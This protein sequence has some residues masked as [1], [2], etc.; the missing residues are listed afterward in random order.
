[1]PVLHYHKW[2]AEPSAGLSPGGQT[3]ALNPRDYTLDTSRHVE[4][5]VRL[6][7]VAGGLLQSVLSTHP[8]ALANASPPATHFMSD[9]CCALHAP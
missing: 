3:D 1:M 2:S 6:R 5:G 9:S 4:V 7:K 8:P